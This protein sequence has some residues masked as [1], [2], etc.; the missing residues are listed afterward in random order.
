MKKRSRQQE[1]GFVNWG[2]KR[3]G[4]G[5]KP[6]GVRA[7]V[8]H[9]KR[10]KLASRFPVLVTMRLCA[11]LRTLRAGDAHAR[12]RGALAASTSARFRV[13]EYSAQA[14][15]LHLLVESS[16]ERALS[17]GMTGLAVRMARALNAEALIRR[18]RV[19]SAQVSVA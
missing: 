16:D 4:A 6:E 11:G 12:I 19:R 14:T 9:A 10:P 3:R 5:R 17:G 15:H 13:I 7:G 18:A 1:F 8:P 2:G